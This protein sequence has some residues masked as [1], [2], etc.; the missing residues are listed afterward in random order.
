MEG[1]AVVKRVSPNREAELVR[2][3][4]AV[5]AGL[6]RDDAL[7]C[8]RTILAHTQRFV[9]LLELEGGWGN[10]SDIHTRT[11]AICKRIVAGG[12]A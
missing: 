2:L 1:G 12:P 8:S 3:A 10:E 4:K 6:S 7:F 9:H 11:L 5:A